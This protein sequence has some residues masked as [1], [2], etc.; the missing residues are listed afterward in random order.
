MTDRGW[1]TSK[2]LTKK[3]NDTHRGKEILKLDLT[4]KSVFWT[5]ELFLTN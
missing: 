3:K 4:N 5:D 1:D 2:Q